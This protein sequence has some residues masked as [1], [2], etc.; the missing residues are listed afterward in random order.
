MITSF[1]EASEAFQTL[2][3][4][5]REEAQRK[6]A[7]AEEFLLSTQPRTLKEAALALHCVVSSLSAGG[8][9]DGLELAQSRR[10]QR[11]MI[12]GLAV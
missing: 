6:Y 7:A 2:A 5:E 12:N 4:D 3:D 11:L 10:V 8:R 9:A 1:E